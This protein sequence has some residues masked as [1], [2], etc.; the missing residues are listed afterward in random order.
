MITTKLR[1]FDLFHWSLADSKGIYSYL[2]WNEG[3]RES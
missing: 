2:S 1:R 3:W